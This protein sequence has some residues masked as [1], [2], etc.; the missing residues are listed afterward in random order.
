MKNKLL[1]LLLLGLI[2]TASSCKTKEVP[3]R[4]RAPRN[5]NTCTKWSYTPQANPENTLLLTDEA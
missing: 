4:R 2:I 3:G 1:I 5:C